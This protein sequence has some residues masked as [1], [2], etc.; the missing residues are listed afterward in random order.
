[1]TYEQMIEMEKRLNEKLPYPVDIFDDY[2]FRLS[3]IRD[4]IRLKLN[5]YLGAKNAK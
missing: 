3:C 5:R 1:M 4:R 2:Q